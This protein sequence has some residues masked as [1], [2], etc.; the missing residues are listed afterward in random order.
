MLTYKEAIE[1]AKALD[2]QRARSGHERGG[3]RA[4]EDGKG[5]PRGGR[6]IGQRPQA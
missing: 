5:I 4:L 3:C 2:P 6:Q 1:L